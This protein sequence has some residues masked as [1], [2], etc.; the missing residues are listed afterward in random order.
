MKSLTEK[1]LQNTINTLQKGGVIVFPTETAYG[2]GVSAKNARAIE[3]VLEIK[4]RSKTK[5]FPLIVADIKMATQ[6]A[7]FPSLLLQ[8]ARR[9]WPGP[10]TIVVPA[11][12]GTGLAKSAIHKDGTIALRV[13]SHPLAQAL[14]KAINS[15]LIATSANRTGDSACYSVRAV[16]KSLKTSRLQPENIVDIG[17]LSKRNP[18]TIIKEKDGKIEVLRQGTIHLPKSYVA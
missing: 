1:Q 6:Y 2:L 13:S 7:E 16:K 17:A 4:G 10:L 8:I 3:K 18:S 12:K 14:S 15:P 9:Y 5:T 11:K